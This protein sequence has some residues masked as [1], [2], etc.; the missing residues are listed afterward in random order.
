MTPD[1]AI[2]R[3]GGLVKD[4]R[5]GLGFRKKRVLHGIDFEVR[6]G[7]VYGFIGPNGAGKTTTLKVLMGL[8]HATA[9]EATVLGHDVRETAYRRHIGYAPE[10]PYFYDF[11]TGREIVEF[12]AR[13]ADVDAA[14]RTHRVGEVLELVGLAHA[15]D[16]R[17][18][19]YSK[20]MLQRIGIAQAIVHDPEVVFLDEPMSGLD[21]VG[22]KEVR[23]LIVD[24]NQAGKSIMMNTHILSDVEMICDRVGIIVD[25]RIA[26]EGSIDGFL[27]DDEK[28]FDVT[29]GALAPDFVDEMAT[30]LRVDPTGR[31]DRVTFSVAE[32]HVSE[33]VEAALRRGG[34]VLE[35]LSRRA[36]LE[37]LFMSAV[38]GSSEEGNE[39]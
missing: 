21:P 28:T 11:L 5:T 2:V 10:S 34:Q 14:K 15:A 8:I 9:G 18:R 3:V 13:L 31:G 7:E 12:Y 39:R 29:L 33:L 4:F 16:E 24:L 19:T 38:Q 17:L 22:R 30:R 23:D 1:D 35:V 26:Y 20:G 36:D 27:P 37:T 25:G 32:K 6:R